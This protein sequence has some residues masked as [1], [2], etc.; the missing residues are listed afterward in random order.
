MR[1]RPLSIRYMA[2]PV[3][4]CLNRRVFCGTILS[5]KRSR[6]LPAASSSRE[7]KSG[8]ERSASSVI[9]L[10]GCDMGSLLNNPPILHEHDPICIT[11]RQL[12][13][14]RDHQYRQRILIDHLAQECDKLVGTNGI[15][16]SRR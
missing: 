7:P 16:I 1:T 10:T 11:V 15:R 13:I 8:T 2:S 9:S 5:E 4:P 12:V 6:K 14:V 3:S